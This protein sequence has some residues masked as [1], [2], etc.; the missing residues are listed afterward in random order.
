M[1]GNILLK[2]YTAAISSKL[3]TELNSLAD[4]ATSALGTEIDNTTELDDTIDFQLDLASVTITST[5]AYV[6][7][8][9]VPT[10]DGTN[11]PD[12]GSSTYANYDA[13]YAVGSI[14]VKN[15]SAAAARANLVGIPIGPGKFKI[16][17]RNMTGAALAASGN[18]V[19]IRKYASS[20][21]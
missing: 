18:T 1:A 4:A 17:I 14:A 16:A 11:Y 6:V 15:V 13:Q 5:S 7:V 20:Y 21:T 10:V 8:Y 2:G 9:L 19:G 3:T 12:W